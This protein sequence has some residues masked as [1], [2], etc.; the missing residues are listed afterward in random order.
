MC[1]ANGRAIRVGKIP[2]FPPKGSANIS[3]NCEIYSTNTVIKPRSTG[4]LGK[5]VSIAEFRS[6]CVRDSG[7]ENYLSFVREAADLVVSL[8]GSL[9]GEHGDGQA[10]GEL[11]PRMF[12]E[13]LVAAFRE[14]K[15]IFDPEWKMNP[16]KVVDPFPID[17][18]LR[19]SP[20]YNPWHPTTRFQFPD[21][22]GSFSEATLRCVGVGKCR[23]ENSGTMCPSYMVTHEEKDSTRGRARL[24]FEMLE[25]DAIGKNGWRDEAVKNALDLCLACKGCKGDCPVNVDMATYKAEFLSHYYEGKI[26]PRHAFAFGFINKWANLASH[27]PLVA[28][29][30]T[31]A[32]VLSDIAKMTAGVA[33]ERNIPQFAPQTFRD[34][35]SQRSSKFKDQ[36]PKS[37]NPKSKIQNQKTDVIL[38]ADTFNNHFHPTTAQAAVE[39]LEAAG[40][41]VKVPKQN[42]CCGRPLYDYGFLD[43]AKKYLLTTL[44]A[45]REPIRQGVSVVVLE[46]SCAAVFRDELINLLPHDEDAKRLHDQ[47]FL[48]SE[49]LEQHDFQPPKL[50]RK[51]IVHGH[52]HHKS[53]MK[54]MDEDN[55]LDKMGL[56]VEVP[57]SGCC[58]MAGAFGFEKGEHYDVSIKCG[59]RVLLPKVREADKTTLLIADGFS[60]REQISQTT[61]RHALH[62][63]QVIKMALDEGENGAS[64]DFPEKKYLGMPTPTSEKIKTAAI[65]GVGALAVGIVVWRTLMKTGTRS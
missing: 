20:E 57:D 64:G 11:L 62:L 6:I 45:L 40:F 28:N 27:L 51:A 34:W 41:R 36:S 21:D 61:N 19:I 53:L 58:G 12:G 10:R 22:D 3:A 9:S 23:R 50:R 25:G 59:E 18:N 14:F 4:I 1:R 33:P 32:P 26:R 60:C 43:G 38:W 39:V 42:L 46:P 24:L 37:E 54:M 55:V 29:F 35:F 47:T 15:K 31:Q 13:D 48:L 8:G 65:A 2:P 30:F 52:C 49:F 5:A 17:A 44:E 63:A 7:I 56:E 16:G